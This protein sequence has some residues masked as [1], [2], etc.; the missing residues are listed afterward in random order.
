MRSARRKPLSRTWMLFLSVEFDCT[1]QPFAVSLEAVSSRIAAPAFG[2]RV[3][4]QSR[5]PPESFAVARTSSSLEGRLITLPIR[6]TTVSLTTVHAGALL[7]D[8]RPDRRGRALLVAAGKR[9]ERRRFRDADDAGVVGVGEAELARRRQGAGVGGLLELGAAR[10]EGG[11]FHHRPGAEQQHR[12]RKAERQGKPAALVMPKLR[13]PLLL[14]GS[15]SGV[16]LRAIR[17][18]CCRIANMRRIRENRRGGRAVP[19]TCPMLTGRRSRLKK[20]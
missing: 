6:L 14:H 3:R 11:I 2:S 16:D 17:Q 13:D 15:P 9:G 5:P 10:G 19:L 20:G 12:Q 8:G 4:T 18:K 1:E 7:H